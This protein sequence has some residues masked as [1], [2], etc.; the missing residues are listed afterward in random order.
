MSNESR[1][2]PPEAGTLAFVFVALILVCTGIGYA[3]D[4]WLHTLPWLMIAGVFVGA[5][6]GFLYLVYILFTSS[7]GRRD[8]RGTV[9]REPKKDEDERGTDSEETHER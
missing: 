9:R 8:P 3:L 7:L 6:V 1:R 5:G 4:R 2:E